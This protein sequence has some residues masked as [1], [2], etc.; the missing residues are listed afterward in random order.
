METCVT[1]DL[2]D[3]LFAQKLSRKAIAISTKAEI[4][5][6]QVENL[7]RMRARGT[8]MY[9]LVTWCEIYLQRVPPELLSDRWLIQAEGFGL[10]IG[11]WSWRIKRFA[12]VIGSSVLLVGTTPL[13]L[14]AALA[15]WAEDQGPVLYNQQR[16]GLYGTEF[17]I[18]KLR[19]MNINAEESGAQWSSP[20]DKRITKVGYWLRRFRIDELPQL[21]NVMKGEMS[22]I[23]PR[24]ERPEIEEQLKRDIP[25]YEI[26]NW[27]RPGLSGW[28][29]VCHP[30]GASLEDSRS[31]LSYDIYYLRNAGWLLDGLIILKTLRIICSSKGSNPTQV[32]V[33]R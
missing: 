33:S 4:S 22:L 15:I 21:I 16:N 9:S 2:N 25:H 26:R 13:L 14:F 17:T 24:P 10:Q 29:Q 18:W 12:D 32:N 31:K 6:Q 28:A 8:R 27:V 7:L 30:Y 20:K 19:S 11:S 1:E 5:N 23:G 3:S